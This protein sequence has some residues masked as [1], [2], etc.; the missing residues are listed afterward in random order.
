MAEVAAKIPGVRPIDTGGLEN[1]VGI[2][3][4]T[5]VLL[6]VNV[7]NQVRSAVRLTGIEHG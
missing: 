5:A 6:S 1:A 4:F 3:A 7:R 2:E